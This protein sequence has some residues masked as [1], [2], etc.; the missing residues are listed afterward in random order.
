MRMLGC[1]FFQPHLKIMVQARFI[2]IYE[3]TAG[4]MHG[5]AQQQSFL[6]PLSARQSSTEGCNIYQ[7]PAVLVSNHI[8]FLYDFI[9]ILKIYV[10]IFVGIRSYLMWGFVIPLI[11]PAE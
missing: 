6:T 3:Y 2:I 5:I 1:K 4:N 11:M 9:I 7:F 8:S 10:Y